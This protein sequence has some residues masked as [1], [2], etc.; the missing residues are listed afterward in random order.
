MQLD[1]L[2]EMDVIGKMSADTREAFKA[3]EQVPITKLPRMT[4]DSALRQHLRE[5]LQLPIVPTGTR[6]RCG[7]AADNRHVRC[8]NAAAHERMARH[9]AVKDIL[10][11]HLG[12]H[13]SVR[14]EVTLLDETMRKRPDIV[15]IL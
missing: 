7:A 2:V 11:S 13:H 5:R 4:Y 3:F 10:A 15:V 8:C 6:C 14:K 9:D 12:K 1:E